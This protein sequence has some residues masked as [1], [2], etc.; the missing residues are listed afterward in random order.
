MRKSK[1]RK[2]IKMK[3]I[4][5][6]EVGD[7]YADRLNADRLSMSK[8]FFCGDDSVDQSYASMC[9]GR[10]NDS[11]ATSSAT[12]ASANSPAAFAASATTVVTT[13]TVTSPDDDTLI[14][15]TS[16]ASA[17]SVGASTSPSVGASTSSS[18]NDAQAFPKISQR[19]LAIDCEMVGVGW[20]MENALARCSII[21]E[22]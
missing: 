2:K 12:T 4:E 19:I 15:V 10:L 14:P 3:K 13:P 11:L 6:V 1:G 21:D 8:T 22:R 18:P 16:T 5:D 7:A 9:T 17:P 20:K